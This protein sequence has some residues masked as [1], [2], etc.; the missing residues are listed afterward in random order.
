MLFKFRCLVSCIDLLFQLCFL[1][2]HFITVFQRIKRLSHMSHD[3]DLI[4]FSV[5]HATTSNI[6]VIYIRPGVTLS[7]PLPVSTALPGCTKMGK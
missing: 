6:V 7:F 2:K 1:H 3:I 5:F 4:E